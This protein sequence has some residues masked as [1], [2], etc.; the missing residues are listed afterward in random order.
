MYQLR[1]FS[2][3]INEMEK[4]GEAALPREET[5]NHFSGLLV[6]KLRFERG[7]FWI[8]NKRNII[9]DNLFGINVSG[10]T[11]AQTLNSSR[12]MSEPT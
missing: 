5:T 4:V 3:K 10:N 7:T 9:L 12:E 2:I 1:W 6:P 8:R 11:P